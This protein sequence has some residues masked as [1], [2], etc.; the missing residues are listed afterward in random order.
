LGYMCMVF[1]H[2]LTTKSRDDDLACESFGQHS[3]LVTH[4]FS[5]ENLLPHSMHR[6]FRELGGSSTSS[7]TIPLTRKLQLKSRPLILAKHN[8]SRGT[9]SLSLAWT[10]SP[11]V[12]D[13][14]NQPI[15]HV[16]PLRL[17]LFLV[18]MRNKTSIGLLPAEGNE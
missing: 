4:I 13:H 9:K 6:R 16:V 11:A 8:F 2:W 7:P 18:H 14:K 3:I 12:P 5:S 17:Y 10:C 15:L 1:T